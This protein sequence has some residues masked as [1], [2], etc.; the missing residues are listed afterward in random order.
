MA[1]QSGVAGSTRVGDYA[2]LAAQSGLRDNIV[3][4]DRAIVGAKSGVSA[5][6]KPGEKVFGIPARPLKDIK[7]MLG[8]MA[9]LTPYA[10][11][12]ARLARDL[13]TEKKTP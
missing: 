1:G 2:I 10:P 6:V 4:G 8:A 7:K 13:G 11:R 5:D 3:I 9:L 12:L